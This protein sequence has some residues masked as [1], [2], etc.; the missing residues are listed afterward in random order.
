[1]PLDATPNPDGNVVLED[2]GTARVLGPLEVLAD[3]RLL[4]MPH[5]ASCPNAGEFRRKR[6]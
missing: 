6:P 1:M 4:Y 3:A 5:H 2:D